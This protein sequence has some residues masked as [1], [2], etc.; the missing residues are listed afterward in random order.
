MSHEHLLLCTPPPRR[1][2]RK[3]ALPL[4][5]VAEGVDQ[6][7]LRIANRT[8]SA[9]EPRHWL[10]ALS[11]FGGDSPPRRAERRAHE[12]KTP[13][14]DWKSSVSAAVVEARSCMQDDLV[15][16]CTK[17][18]GI[19]PWVAWA[20]ARLWLRYAIA[21][22]PD[23]CSTT[24]DIDHSF[25][26]S[27]WICIKMH[28]DLRKP[29]MEYMANESGVTKS[30]LLCAEKRVLEQLGVDVYETAPPVHADMLLDKWLHLFHPT[31]TGKLELLV[32][33]EELMLEICLDEKLVHASPAV[34]SRGCMA[35]VARCAGLDDV[36]VRLVGGFDASRALPARHLA[37]TDIARALCARAVEARADPGCALV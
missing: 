21:V 34:L 26:S 24:H 29:S 6:P 32:E 30:E 14:P 23:D 17:E 27:L 35:A 2:A 31:G 16:L 20:S 9:E 5:V 28:D 19:N 1:G 22:G 15:E 7:C 33:C 12:N 10:R 13:P 36:A 25:A 11:W 4:E 18:W 3:R 37:A 8:R